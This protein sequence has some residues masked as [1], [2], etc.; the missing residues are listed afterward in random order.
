MGIIKMPK[1]REAINIILEKINDYVIDVQVQFTYLRDALYDLENEA[2]D[3]LNHEEANHCP[4]QKMIL[5][6]HIVFAENLLNIFEKFNKLKS[7]N[8]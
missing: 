2:V 3:A 5:N 4:S 1:G 8:S 6:E 7:T